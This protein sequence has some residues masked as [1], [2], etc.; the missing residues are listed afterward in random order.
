VQQVVSGRS[1][2]EGVLVD[3]VVDQPVPVRQLPV[4]LLGREQIAAE[5]ARVQADKAMRAAYEAELVLALADDSPDT[6]DPAPDHPGARRRGW[7][8]DADLAGISEFFVHEL[9]MIVNCGRGTASV[10]AQRAWTWREKLPATFAALAAGELDEPRAKALA[11]VLEVT[12]ADIARAVEAQVLPQASELSVGKL[13]ARALQRLLELDAEAADA[14]RRQAQRTA[15]VRCYPSTQDGM[16]T[17]AA[18]LPT[19]VSA[20]C[21]AMVDTLARMLKADGD[22]RP[23][24]QLRATVLAD[25]IRRPWNPELPP[26]TAQVTVTASL[27]SLTGQG[28]EPGAV[29]GLPITAAHL[30][31]LLI[32]LG[33]LGLQAPDGGALRLAIT[34]GEGRLLATATPG[35]LRRLA[36]RGCR[37]HPGAN[38]SCPVL[39]VPAATAA[40][41]PTDTQRA[42]VTTRDGTCRFPNCGQRVGWA[43]LD[44]VIA[45]ADGGSTDCTNL[46][47]LCRTHHR[48][49]T[50]AAGWRFTMTAD[51][52]LQV[53]TPSGITR[54]TRPP[55]LQPPEPE[56]CGLAEPPGQ[57]QPDDRAGPP[58]AAIPD[59]DLPPF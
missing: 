47:C 4:E 22:P 27:P 51:G 6:A 48:L 39:G 16:S 5:L 17:L 35:R 36:A 25:L 3:W 50:F 40:Y 20:E 30:R 41:A 29:D 46:C 59:D 18:D 19:P 21:Y 1:S 54:T 58:P 23:I 28:T 53:T 7:A 14:R 9:A 38:C 26:V 49:K 2:L 55:G 57:I 13:K 43:D 10:L 24:G 33:A 45:H 15:D 12:S 56:P 44:H 8:A 31:E 11:D 52:T 37:T 32:Q 34:D 42:W